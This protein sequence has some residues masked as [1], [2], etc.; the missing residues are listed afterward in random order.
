M[1]LVSCQLFNTIFLLLLNYTFYRKSQTLFSST[2]LFSPLTKNSNSNLGLKLKFLAKQEGEGRILPLPLENLLEGLICHFLFIPTN[3]IYMKSY[4][5]FRCSSHYKI[6]PLYY[7]NTK[8]HI[9]K[10]KYGT[11]LF[12]RPSNLVFLG[13]KNLL[14]FSCPNYCNGSKFI[15][16]LSRE[17][18]LCIICSLWS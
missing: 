16:K 15:W 1:F 14:V 13:S 6:G 17:C 12:L 8:S 10:V 11:L 18:F 9:K 3:I 4:Q 7:E 5:K 2:S